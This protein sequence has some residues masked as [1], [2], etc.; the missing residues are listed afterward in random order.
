MR[1]DPVLPYPYASLRCAG[2]D[3]AACPASSDPGVCADS[4]ATVRGC[5]G[6]RWRTFRP[7]RREA[8]AIATLLHGNIA[9]RW[10][11]G[12]LASHVCLSTGQ[13]NRVFVAAFGVT[14]I[15]YLAILRVQEMARLIRETDLLITEI[16][17]RVG[18]GRHSGYA[19]DVFRRCTGITP[20]TTAVTGRQARAVTDRASGWPE[21][22]SVHPCAD[23]DTA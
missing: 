21:P 6:P 22:P 23:P 17:E 8:A 11:V 12:D 20:S 2:R 13:S 1:Y 19:T 4:E 14:P 15:V 7:T 16:T 18:W 9:R 3:C 10:R 5:C